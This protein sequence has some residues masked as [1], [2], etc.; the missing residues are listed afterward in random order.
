MAKEKT[1]IRM[2][3]EFAHLASGAVSTAKPEWKRSKIFLTYTHLWMVHDSSKDRIPL[4]A[5]TDVG[6]DVSLRVGMS[7]DRYVCLDYLINGNASILVITSTKDQIRKLKRYILILQL[8]NASVYLL[9]PSKIGGVL[10]PNTKWLKGT[11]TIARETGRGGISDTLIFKMEGTGDV[12]IPLDN[13]EQSIKEERT[14]GKNKRQVI[15]VTHTSDDNNFET[16]IFTKNINQLLEYFKDYLQDRGVET[17]VTAETA[18]WAG[19]S[20]G[21]ELS[22]MEDEVMIALYS[23]VSSLE[24]ESMLENVNVDD[25]EKIYDR[26]INDGL[27]ETIRIRKEI[28]LTGK[29]KNIV[30]KK[31]A[32]I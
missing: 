9:H 11:L 15:N 5:I 27:A 1:L 26:L 6:R 2:E 16:C 17:I 19:D 29:G 22:A 8:N 31:M 28:Q 20:E 24:M 12:K 10:Q 13:V 32:A 18:M 30:N 23:G 3:G 7:I 25:L 21:P 4:N 14:I